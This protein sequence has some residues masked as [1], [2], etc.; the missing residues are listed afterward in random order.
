MGYMDNKI[1]SRVV[2]RNGDLRDTILVVLEGPFDVLG[3]G[4]VEGVVGVDDF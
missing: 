2:G 4:G 3:V 1:V